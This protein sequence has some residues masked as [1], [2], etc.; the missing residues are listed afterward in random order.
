[1]LLMRFTQFENNDINNEKS[2]MEISG[3]DLQMA[4]GRK[5]VLRYSVM[6]LCR[7]GGKVAS[8]EIM[9]YGNVLRMSSLRNGNR[10]AV[11]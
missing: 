5:D 10:Q 8:V 2:G 7:K 11:V 1:M 6:S 4:M 9:V 3:G